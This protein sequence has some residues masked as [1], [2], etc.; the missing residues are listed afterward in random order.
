MSRDTVHTTTDRGGLAGVARL[1][2]RNV[3][4]VSLS[5][6]TGLLLVANAVAAL[7]P[8]EPGLAQEWAARMFEVTG[9]DFGTIARGAK[10]E[11]A[12]EVT[13][14]YPES[15]RI[16]GVRSNCGCSAPRV[17]V[18]TIAPQQTGAV[19]VRIN[20]QAFLGN[21]RATITVTFDKPMRAEVQLHVKVYV[22]RDVLIE[23]AAVALG[24]V[25]L[26]TPAEQTVTVRHTGRDDW[27]IVDVR[28]DN[29]HLTATLTQSQRFGNRVTYSLRI[30]LDAL[31][32]HG[33]IKDHV[34]LVTDDPQA[35]TLPVPVEGHVLPSL[36]VSPAALFLGALQPG[37]TIARQIVV[38]GRQP[39][40]I[41][42]IHGSCGALRAS[43][44]S[45]D[46]PK[47]LH[48][49][50]V[51]FTAGE[52]SGQATHT[53]RIE[54]DSAESVELHAHVL[55]AEAPQVNVSRK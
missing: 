41:T 45:S 42:G 10:A 3:L 44:P 9:H 54:T 52:Q 2:I 28:S 55:V 19:I 50:S 36:A 15:V 23:P 39:F 4:K 26:G 5:A 7:V 24:T 12:F 38:R 20:S 35:E 25:P 29:P 6:R 8:A 31:A 46:E 13:N 22:Y 30:A 33:Y 47:P 14:P 49:V 17:D 21:Q 32:P 27:R 37:Q 40:R 1:G 34:W 18:D 11:F 16:A 43:V 48:L 51:S 53:L